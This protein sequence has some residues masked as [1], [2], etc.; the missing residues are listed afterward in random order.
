MRYEGGNDPIEPFAPGEI[1][2]VKL[3]HKD[4]TG[5]ESR[6][7]TQTVRNERPSIES[8][9]DDFRFAAAVAEWGML[10]RDSKYK[11][12]SSYG[13]V[14]QLARNSQGADLEGYRAE[15]IRLVEQSRGLSAE[16]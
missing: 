9:G 16:K 4:P 11:G 3:R 5:T 6:L 15:F 12:R 1:M 14:L 8:S 2:R 10:L 7:T 13:Q